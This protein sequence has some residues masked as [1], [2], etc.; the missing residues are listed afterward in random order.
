MNKCTACDDTGYLLTKTD[1][2]VKREACWAC[3]GFHPHLVECKRVV[4]LLKGN[5]LGARE[6]KFLKFIEMAVLEYENPASLE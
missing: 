4:E 1:S 5:N 6:R 2:E 3:S